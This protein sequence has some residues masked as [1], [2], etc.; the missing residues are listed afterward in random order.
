MSDWH[1]LGPDDILLEGTMRSVTAGGE[2]ILLARVN[3]IYYGCQERCPHM[4]ARL[5]KGRFSDGEVTCPAHGSRFAIADGKNLA[6][7]ESLPAI[8]GGL[9]RLVVKP[10]DL[11]TYPVRVRAG[12]V[13]V[14]I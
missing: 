9:V 10:K 5:S 7:V 3:G 13:E 6:W 4:R 11:T 12:R 2:T 1:D 14:R 8:V